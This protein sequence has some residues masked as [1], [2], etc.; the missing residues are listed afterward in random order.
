MRREIWMKKTIV[1][2]LCLAMLMGLAVGCSPAATTGGTTGGTTAATTG[3]TTATTTEALGPPKKVVF[4]YIAAGIPKDQQLINDELNKYILPLI[5]VEVELM[6][7]DNANYEQQC[8]LMITSRET[9]DLM[10]IMQ[11]RPSISFATM[12]SQ[13]MLTDL[14]EMAPQ[15]AQGIFDEINRV[16]PA[17]IDGTK[18]DGRLYAFTS[19]FDKASSQWLAVRKDILD[20]NNLKLNTVKNVNDLEAMLDVIKANEKDIAPWFD[21][22]TVSFSTLV[23]FDD[24]S[25]PYKM[26]NL[27]DTAF[28]LGV[29]IGNN[30]NT[31]VVNFYETDYYKSWLKIA[32]RWYQKDLIYKD[33][34]TTNDRTDALVSAGK[35]AA[36]YTAGEADYFVNVN[37]RAN[38]EMEVLNIGQGLVTTGMIQ[39]FAWGVPTHSKEPEAA[40]KF[41]TLTYTDDYVLNLINFGIEGKHYVVNPDK[42]ISFPE[43]IDSKTVDYKGYGTFIFGSQFRAK[44]FKP[45]SAELR[46][47]ALAINK[48]AVNSI[49]MGFTVDGTPFRN[50]LTAVT[51]VLAQY[52]KT[53]ECGSV[54]P[55]VVLP[56]FL[57]AL[58]SA[59]YS[60][61]IAEVQRQVDIF[62]AK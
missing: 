36:M 24:F 43:G 23:N 46:E 15:Y 51:N 33:Y 4:A 17:Y 7:I 18:V 59:G 26:D 5:N 54:D 25:K 32:R 29:I 30:D 49:L 11:T 48:N 42:T 6:P 9:L 62:M 52:R 27:G 38:R 39:K 44:V 14:T 22:M 12:T 55:D 60:K 37:L 10:L 3:A 56:E 40:L 35:V 21:P 19:L 28:R 1:L 20:K 50:E 31:N 47:Q 13:K 41:L 45:G 58:E 53:L 16:N 61:I 8:S 34:P 2:V 57:A